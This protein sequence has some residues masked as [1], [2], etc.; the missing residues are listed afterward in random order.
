M[1][2]FGTILLNKGKSAVKDNHEMISVSKLRYSGENGEDARYPEHHPKV[3]R[4]LCRVLTPCGL[5]LS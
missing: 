1:S 2:R 5:R 4:H 3:V